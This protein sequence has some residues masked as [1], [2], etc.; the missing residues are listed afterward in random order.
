[1]KKILIFVFLVLITGVQVS[2]SQDQSGL[3]GYVP[4]FNSTLNG[5]RYYPRNL[6]VNEIADYAFHF[7]KPILINPSNES[8]S[9]KKGQN[10]P[11][12]AEAQRQQILL[13]LK[14]V[15]GLIDLSDDE[16]ERIFK[17]PTRIEKAPSRVK[18]TGLLTEGSGKVLPG[19]TGWVVRDS[20]ITR[21]KLKTEYMAVYEG[22][23]GVY[24]ISLVCGNSLELEVFKLKVTLPPVEKTEP[25]IIPCKRDPIIIPCKTEPVIIPCKN[26]NGS[27]GSNGKAP[28][29]IGAGSNNVDTRTLR[30]NVNKE[31]PVILGSNNNNVDPKTLR[32]EPTKTTN[33][34]VP[35]R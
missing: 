4:Q 6:S 30:P 31:A 24:K 17:N 19:Q 7:K 27:A 21:D 29:I 1:M 28:I 23:Y 26:G 18:S 33:G 10:W 9:G 3:K 2:Y 22:P 14:T 12:Y 35:A 25:V 20:Y 8:W 5:V 15:Y 32:P 11:G 34:M 13:G 16:A